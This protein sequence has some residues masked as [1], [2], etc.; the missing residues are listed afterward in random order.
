MNKPKIEDCKGDYPY[1]TYVTYSK[2][3]EKYIAE[4][5]AEFKVVHQ[6]AGDWMRKNQDLQKQVE[7]L[8]AICTNVAELISTEEKAHLQTAWH[9]LDNAGF[10]KNE[11]LKPKL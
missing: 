10:T 8:E 7:E 11:L 4:L 1:D 2:A 5:D 9:I 3:L 6:R